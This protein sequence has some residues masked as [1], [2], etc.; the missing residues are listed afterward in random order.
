[1]SDRAL[2]GPAPLLARMR[3]L[4]G[5]AFAPLGRGH[6]RLCGRVARG[7][8]RRST[9]R[10]D[11]ETQA[12]CSAARAFRMQRAWCCA[13]VEARGERRGHR[14]Q[15]NSR[16]APTQATRVSDAYGWQDAA[17]N[18]EAWSVVEP[19]FA[20]PVTGTRSVPPRPVPPGRFV[21]ASS[22]SE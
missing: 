16:D 18:K 6:T 8:R 1:M 19:S 2:L 5:G 4:E 15:G 9:P 20:L 13:R 10:A 12:L 14:D 22:Q 7:A 21:T 11:A 3:D 17:L